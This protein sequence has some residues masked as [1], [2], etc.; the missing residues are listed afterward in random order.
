MFAA[1][2]NAQTPEAGSTTWTTTLGPPP[3][4]APRPST[5]GAMS[6]GSPSATSSRAPCSTSAKDSSTRWAAGGQPRGRGASQRP[7][8][9]SVDLFGEQGKWWLEMSV[10]WHWRFYSSQWNSSNSS[11]SNLVTQCP[12]SVFLDSVHVSETEFPHL[13]SRTGFLFWS[14]HPS[15]FTQTWDLKIAV[16]SPIPCLFKSKQSPKSFPFYCCYWFSLDVY[17][18]TG[19]EGWRDLKVHLDLGWA[20]YGLWAKRAPS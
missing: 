13:S 16:T 14:L 7:R 15:P 18:L 4:S 2:R 12:P 10:L 8:T 3:G 6:S 9:F 17:Y 5:C 19:S 11:V 1:G 20:N